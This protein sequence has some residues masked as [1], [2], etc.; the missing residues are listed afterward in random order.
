MRLL[1]FFQSY[2]L[3]GHAWG[4]SA[5]KASCREFLEMYKALSEE[6]LHHR[7]GGIRFWKVNPKFHMFQKLGEYQ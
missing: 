3:M 4:A 5:A 7:G 2:C 6:P 1:R